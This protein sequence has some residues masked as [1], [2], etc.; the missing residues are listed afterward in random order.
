VGGGGGGGGGQE[1]IERP[2]GVA[3]RKLVPWDG[4]GGGG[5]GGGQKAGWGSLSSGRSAVLKLNDL[6][7]NAPSFVQV[8]DGADMKGLSEDDILSVSEVS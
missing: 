3:A 4:G 2:M 6:D 8:G 1:V 7:R 5:G